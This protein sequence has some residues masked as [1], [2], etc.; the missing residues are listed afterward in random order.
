MKKL[1]L[2]VLVFL[3]AGCSQIQYEDDPAQQVMPIPNN[4]GV[5]RYVDEEAGVVCWIYSAYHKGGISCF[6]LDDTL[7]D[8]GG[9]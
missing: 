2:L 3:L 4:Y 5:V 1:V 7:L 6:P 8:K 9:G